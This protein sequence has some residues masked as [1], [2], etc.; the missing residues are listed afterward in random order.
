MRFRVDKKLSVPEMEKEF[1]NHARMYCDQVLE[2][3]FMS[4]AALAKQRSML[5]YHEAWLERN[6]VETT[7]LPGQMTLFEKEVRLID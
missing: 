4:S 3:G 5:Q 6:K 1:L 2:T 7:V